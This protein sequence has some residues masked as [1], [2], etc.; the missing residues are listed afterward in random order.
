M[1]YYQKN[2]YGFLVEMPAILAVGNG[3]HVP[4][5]VVYHCSADDAL[6][7][8]HRPCDRGHVHGAFA[9]L[10]DCHFHCDAF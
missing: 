7:L 8:H 1:H 5:T 4:P 3:V 9:S 10:V 2:Y 6:P